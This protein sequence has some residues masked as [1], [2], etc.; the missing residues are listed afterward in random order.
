MADTKFQ[1]NADR[2]LE[3]IKNAIGKSLKYFTTDRLPAYRKSFKRVFGKNTQHCFNIHLKGDI[4]N[5]KID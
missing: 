5:N 1:H 2:L 3:L 4:Q